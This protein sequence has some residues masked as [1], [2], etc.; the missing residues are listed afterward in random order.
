MAP[1]ATIQLQRPDSGQH[2]GAFF[3]KNI[4]VFSDAS[5][6]YIPFTFPVVCDTCQ[7]QPGYYGP[8]CENTARRRAIATRMASSTA[9][10]SVRSTRA[11][12]RPANAVAP[13]PIRTRTTT[14]R[15]TATTSAHSTRRT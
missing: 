3:A 13:S 10:T 2:R 9:T 8:T 1:N 4:E 12:R 11:R 15:R 5:V 7:C 14:A 6:D